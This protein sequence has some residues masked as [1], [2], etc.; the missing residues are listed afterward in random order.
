MNSLASQIERAKL[1][2][3]IADELLTAAEER[4]REALEH[5]K[6]ARAELKIVE[7]VIHREQTEH[8]YEQLRLQEHQL[9]EQAAQ[10]YFRAQEFTRDMET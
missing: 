2:I 8:R 5:H 4:L 7:E 10:A 1:D 6:Q 9:Q 3:Q